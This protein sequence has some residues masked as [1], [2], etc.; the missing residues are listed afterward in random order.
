MRRSL[1]AFGA[2]QFTD[3]FFQIF[4]RHS[5]GYLVFDHLFDHLWIK[6]GHNPCANNRGFEQFAYCPL[7]PFVSACYPSISQFVYFSPIRIR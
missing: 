7:Q 6:D 5:F 4:F 1:L 2:F 3:Q